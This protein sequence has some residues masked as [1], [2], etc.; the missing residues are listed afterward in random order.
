MRLGELRGLLC[1]W[2]PIGVGPEWAKDEYDCLLGPLLTELENSVSVAGLVTFL[3]AELGSLGV[4][5]PEA[6][7]RAFAARAH[8]WFEQAGL[9]EGSGE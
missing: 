1:E 9:K 7:V 5:P 8:V 6:G 3:K 4:E 2:D